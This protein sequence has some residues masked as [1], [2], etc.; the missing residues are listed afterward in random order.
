MKNDDTSW[1]DCTFVRETELAML[2]EIEGEELWIPKSQIGASK[3]K[4]GK[5]IRVELTDWIARQKGLL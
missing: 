4:D 1:F 2:L 5:P 3:K